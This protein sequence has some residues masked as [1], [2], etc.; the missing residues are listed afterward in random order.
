MD[1]E[2]PDLAEQEYDECQSDLLFSVCGG[3]VQWM[4]DVISHPCRKAPIVATILEY[5]P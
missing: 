1:G 5:V 3:C 2:V 4:V